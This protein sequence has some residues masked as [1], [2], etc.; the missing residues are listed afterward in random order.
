MK[1]VAA[2]RQFGDEG[3]MRSRKNQNYSLQFKLSVVESYLTGE[4]SY[5]DLAMQCGINNPSLISRWVSD[6]RTGGLDAL[7]PKKKGRKTLN[8]KYN[9]NAASSPIWFSLLCFF[10]LKSLH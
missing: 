9:V 6:F 10:F 3:L 7:R 1:W 2:Y 4:I 8:A 5:R